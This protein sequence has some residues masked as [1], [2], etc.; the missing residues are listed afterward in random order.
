MTTEAEQLRTTVA[1]QQ[2]RIDD[3]NSLCMFNERTMDDMLE[4]LAASQAREKVLRDAIERYLPESDH[5]SDNGVQFYR[6]LSDVL[7]Q[8]TDDSALRELLKAERERV[9]KV[10]RD[11]SFKIQSG[12]P[13]RKIFDAVVAEIRAMENQ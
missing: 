13:H 9:A 1:E 5:C 10:V 4:Q 6:E 3:M 8:P 7:D 12:S 2:K 11:A